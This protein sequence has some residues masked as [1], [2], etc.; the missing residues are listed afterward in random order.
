MMT[1]IIND[2]FRQ[3]LLTI[4]ED[5]TSEFVKKIAELGLRTFKYAWPRG[6]SGTEFGAK[7]DDGEVRFKKAEKDGVRVD[8]FR[9]G[10]QHNS[11]VLP[12]ELGYKY[13]PDGK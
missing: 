3:F 9:N 8:F 13:I 12:Y 2:E 11:Y 6:E 5:E 4:T 10:E 7:Y 1:F